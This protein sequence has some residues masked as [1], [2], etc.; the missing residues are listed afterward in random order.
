MSAVAYHYD[1][2]VR[3]LALAPIDTALSPSV[4]EY[5]DVFI[6]VAQ[7]STK[8]SCEPAWGASSSSAAST[9]V[10]PIRTVPG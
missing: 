1:E 6:C 10:A 7:R 3:L 2:A 9:R 4:Q 8:A 5:K